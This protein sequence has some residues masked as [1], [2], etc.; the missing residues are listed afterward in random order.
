MMTERVSICTIS[1][2]VMKESRFLSTMLGGALDS[3]G[4]A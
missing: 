4:W 1:L 3:H 2:R